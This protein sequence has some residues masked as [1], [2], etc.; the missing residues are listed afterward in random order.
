MRLR[1]ILRSKATRAIGA[2]LIVALAALAGWWLWT[3][4][5]PVSTAT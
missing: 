3:V 1:E 5:A 4:A 2:L